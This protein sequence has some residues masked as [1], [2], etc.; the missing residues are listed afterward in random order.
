MDIEEFEAWLGCLVKYQSMYRMLD[1]E[2]TVFRR[3]RGSE[4]KIEL[5]RAELKGIP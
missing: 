2:M 4:T 5:A 1:T 3:Y